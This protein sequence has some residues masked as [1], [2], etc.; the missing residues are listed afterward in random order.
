[1]RNILKTGESASV[2]R[3]IF[4][5]GKGGTYDCIVIMCKLVTDIR[6][7]QEIEEN[8]ILPF[9]KKLKFV[10]QQ[11]V[12]FDRGYACSLQSGLQG[13]GTFACETVSHRHSRRWG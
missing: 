11:A 3:R 4:Y 5:D 8:L 9:S 10:L 6:E 1:M 2:E 7:T 12:R 13:D